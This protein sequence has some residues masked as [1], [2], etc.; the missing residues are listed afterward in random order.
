MY[1][2]LLKEKKISVTQ[3]RIDILAMLNTANE[4]L[5]IDMMKQKM[6]S[7]IDVSTLYRSLK[8]MVDVGI[9]YQTDFREGV[10]YFE[11]QGDHHHHIVCTRCK[12]RSSI[13]ACLNQEILDSANKTGYTITNHIFELFGLCKKCSTL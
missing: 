2:K 5:T 11:F 6:S 8:V 7:A 4:P 1:R 12:S 13:D 3:K 10:S 9:I